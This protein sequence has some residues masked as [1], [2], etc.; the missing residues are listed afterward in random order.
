MQEP[1]NWQENCEELGVLTK[2]WCCPY[3]TKVPRIIIQHQNA[4]EKTCCQTQLENFPVVKEMKLLSSNGNGK[5]LRVL[6][7]LDRLLSG[8][9]AEKH[10]LLLKCNFY[11]CV[12]T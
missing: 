2:V 7:G 12:I 3:D 8:I 4:R 11:Y 1:E 5:L 6:D 10:A 9:R